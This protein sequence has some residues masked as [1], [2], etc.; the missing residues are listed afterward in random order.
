MIQKSDS[1]T[2]RRRS[3]RL[4]EF[5]YSQP[6]LY[7]VTIVTQQRRCIFGE[8]VDGEVQLS[9]AGKTVSE[10]LHGIS[11]R[12][13]RVAVDLFVVMPNDI[14]VVVN[15]G[16]QFIAPGS[17]QGSQEDAMNRAPICL[18]VSARQEYRIQ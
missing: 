12:F 9:S 1:K 11:D 13:P 17:V 2:D 10:M 6:G 18:A 16:A 14:R 15:I 8:V 4:K 5:D 7:F 3:I